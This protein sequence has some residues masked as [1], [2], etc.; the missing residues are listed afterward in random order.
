[1]HQRIGIVGGAGYVGSS[2]ARYLCQ[3]FEVIVVD[4]KRP[5]D[6]N[7]GVTFRQCDVRSYQSVSAALRDT[8]LVIHTAI[9]QIPQINER[10]KLGYEVNVEGTQNVCKAVEENANI[11]GMILAGTWHTIG[12]RDIVGVV[13]E[14]FGLRPDKVEERAVIYALSKMAQESIVRLY[15]EMSEKIFGIIRM[16]TVLGEEMPRGTAA[17]IFI[18]KGIKGENITPFRNSMY[19]PMLYVDIYDICRAYDVFV[20]KILSGECE[21]KSNSAAN[22]VNVY[23]PKPVT[24]LR[25]AE[26]VK[27]AIINGSCDEIT[28]QIEIVDSGLPSIFTE[29]DIERFKIDSRKAENYLGLGKLSTP[30]ESIDRIV[31]KRLGQYIKRPRQR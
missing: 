12:E 5:E 7:S 14:E 11:K 9:I 4:V 17:S 18:E 1:M 19:R 26:I 13:N 25:L 22:I 20:S 30:Q 24:I 10:K 29:N 27:N 31:K 23:Y 3:K 8:D 2:I 15:D 21:K 28:P 16:G 6:P